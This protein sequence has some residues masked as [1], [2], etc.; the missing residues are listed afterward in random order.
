[1]REEEFSISK[2][3]ILNQ[4]EAAQTGAMLLQQQQLLLSFAPF[5]C[6]ATVYYIKVNFSLERQLLML[7]LLLLR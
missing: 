7:L 5:P 3:L 1:V 4:R 2:V 6:L